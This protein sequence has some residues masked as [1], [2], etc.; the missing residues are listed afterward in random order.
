MKFTEIVLCCAE[1]PDQLQNVLSECEKPLVSSQDGDRLQLIFRRLWHCKNDDQQRSWPIHEDEALIL[2]L[3]E[4]LYTILVDA[5]PRV[6][7][8]VLQADDYDYVSTLA[9]YY[10][11]GLCDTYVSKLPMRLDSFPFELTE[12]VGEQFVRFLLDTIES[13]EIE[14]EVAELSLGTL[15]S[16]NLHLQS[17]AGNFVLRTLATRKDARALTERLM[18]LV[19]RE[20]ESSV[21]CTATATLV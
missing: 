18:L 12:H 2:G 14:E 21:P 3:L 15:L 7:R 5:D 19:N 1:V 4:E 20:G 17:E 9:L 6:S 13:A 11:M 16:L 8:S 10:Q